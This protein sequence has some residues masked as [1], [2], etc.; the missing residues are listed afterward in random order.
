MGRMHIGFYTSIEGWGGS[1][2]YLLDLMRGVVRRGHAV[3]LFGV[4][5][6][7]LWGVAGE[8][9]LGCVAIARADSGQ[10]RE[11]AHVMPAAQ[12]F[13]ARTLAPRWVR[14]LLG[15]ANEVRRLTR[16]FGGHRVDVMH[17]AVSGYE[18]AGLACRRFGVPTVAMNMVTP[19]EESCWMRRW[20][21][22]YTQRRYDHVSSQSA[23]CTEQWIRIAGLN[24]AKCSH[25]WNGADLSVF[26]PPDT[27]RVREQHDPLRLVSL[28]RLHPMKGY[29]TLIDAVAELADPRI[30]ATIY[31]EG[32]QRGELEGRV[33]AHDISE[34]VKLPGHTEDAAEALRAADA[35]VLPSVSHESCPAVLAQAMATGL[36]LITSDFGPLAEVN[37][38]EQ[39]GLVFPAGNASALA[40][41]IRRLTD[42]PEEAEQMGC[43]ALKRAR[44]HLSL[45]QMID[46]TL[47]LYGSVGAGKAD[48]N[49][50]G[51]QHPHLHLMH[52]L[53]ADK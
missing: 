40:D 27:P 34:R 45:D 20:L 37:R 29:A 22:R 21:M 52:F 49:G 44:A 5:G 26:T 42:H 18:V 31:G 7:R 32:G 17:V 16:V 19:P 10:A 8:S 13:K 9:G 39:S 14:L 3:T 1:E 2:S 30:Q 43:R 15:N 51:T 33:R 53:S 25:V 47:R 11:D 38:H 12:R 4:E 28:G 41:A 36:P 48:S 35:F 50:L 24:P 23:Y 6:T 46:Q